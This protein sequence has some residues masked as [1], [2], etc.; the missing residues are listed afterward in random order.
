[1]LKESLRYVLQISIWLNA[2]SAD[3]IG[4]E[5]TYQ[6]LYHCPDNTD[7][8]GKHDFDKE[9]CALTCLMYDDCTH[10]QWLAPDGTNPCWLR[11]GCVVASNATSLL[12]EK[13]PDGLSLQW[14][15]GLSPP[16]MMEYKNQ[17]CGQNDLG[18]MTNMDE[19]VCN[20]ICLLN[21]RCHGVVWGTSRNCY[22]KS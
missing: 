6:G 8:H 4:E 9:V 17:H 19:N 3:L 5:Y 2:N 13:K 14:K 7:R 15:S 18:W 12:Y 20:F 10:F 22:F 11:S 16:G 21:E 1:M